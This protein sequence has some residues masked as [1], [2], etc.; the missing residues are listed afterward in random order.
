MNKKEKRFQDQV[1][2]MNFDTE[3]GQPNYLKEL[4]FNENFYLELEEWS[5]KYEKWC[6]SDLEF[7]AEEYFL[8]HKVN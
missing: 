2:I 7:F 6:I 1:I 4:E 3:E 8:S 5:E